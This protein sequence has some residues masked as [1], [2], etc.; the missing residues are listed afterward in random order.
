MPTGPKSFFWYELMTTDMDAAEAFYR[1]VVGWEGEP[2]GGGPGSQY[3]VMNIGGKPVSGVMPLPEEAG[4]GGG[5]PA[6]LGHIHAGD[7]DAA[8]EGVRQAGGAVHR[9]PADIPGIGRFSVVADPQGAIFMLFKPTGGDNPPA[10]AMTPGHIGWHELYATDWSKAFDFYAGQFGWTKA[11]AVD[12]GAMGTYQT[13]AAGGEAIGGMMD[14]PAHIPSPVWLFY[15]NVPAIDA[16]AADVEAG[17][18]HVLVGPIQVPGGGWIVQCTDP[19][20]AMFALLAQN[21]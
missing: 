5:R 18:G 6:W 8:T 14:K 9:A 20:G 19:Q 15:F 10:P 13:F 1:D 21:R 11:Q 16:A 2:W 17:G 4:T 3:T 12:M 7:V